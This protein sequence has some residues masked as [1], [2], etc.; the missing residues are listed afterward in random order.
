M[1]CGQ[2]STPPQAQSSAK[3]AAAAPAPAAAKP[4]DVKVTVEEKVGE[5]AEA[6]TEE[7]AGSVRDLSVADP[8]AQKE[9]LLAKDEPDE[10]APVET[11]WGRFWFC[12]TA[13]SFSAGILPGQA[14]FT[15]LFVNAGIFGSMCGDKGNGCK[16]QYVTMTGIFQTGMS[17][18]LF[19]MLPIGLLFDRY[20]AQMVGAGGAL[21]CSVG[22]LLVWGSILGAAAGMDDSTSSLFVVGVLVT[23]FGSFLNSFAM[24]GLVWH[25]PGRQA[26]FLALTTAT[27]Q[28]SAFF[29]II[30]EA[31]MKSTGVSL[32]ACL[33]AWAIMVVFFAW[34]CW[35]FVP[36]QLEYYDTA[37]KVLGMPLPK[38]PK[39]FN[40]CKLIRTA[41]EV[42]RLDTKD[43]VIC[44]VAIAFGLG[45]PMCYQSFTAPFGK[46]IFGSEEAG[47]KLSNIYVW[48]NAV[49]GCSAAPFA[50]HLVDR[51]GLMKFCYLLA[52]MLVVA[53]GTIY[54]TNWACQV[55]CMAMLI[56]WMLL[57]QL[58]FFRYLLM[59]VP[60]NRFGAAQGVYIA[61]MCTCLAMPIQFVAIGIIGALPQGAS[62][63]QLPF[64]ALASIGAVAMVAY[65]IYFSTHPPPE[66]PHLIG[67]DEKD[68]AKGFGCDTLEEVAYVTR[69][70]TRMEILKK[71]AKQDADSIKDVIKSIDTERMM[72][73]MN[74][75]SVDDIADMMEEAGGDEEEEEAAEEAAPEPV[76]E[77]PSKQEP[78]AETAKADPVKELSDKMIAS[79][80]AKDGDAIKNMFMTEPV[81]DLDKVFIFW[82]DNLPPKVQ[83]DN[84]KAF[85][86]LIPGK[87]FAKMLRERPDLKKLI[88]N[89]MKREMDKKIAKFR[90]KK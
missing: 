64:L 73:M 70:A 2:S 9:P 83:K 55:T 26:L 32:A 59:Y 38:P 61:L 57:F 20:G 67:D 42:L 90:G 49:L 37:K 78:A 46:A 24:Y 18:T 12:W 3:P 51:F 39:D 86:K 88:Q 30:I 27:Y 15:E 56:M 65:A 1:G 80:A 74:K 87:E 11:P 84:E 8:E 43:H 28:I 52:G 19:L 66:I 7:P 29:P 75:R 6:K 54:F 44:G 77:E 58:Y 69:N 13:C 47:D 25:F 60:P 33:F 4:A 85:N 68:L 71:L 10:E 22:T 81:E 63:Y 17:L 5:Q 76:K 89:M 50:G 45:L 41:W 53:A 48:L 72:E 36:S 21:I 62:A 14:L 34:I 23:D 40:F 82:E 35:K 31:L 79:L 16:D